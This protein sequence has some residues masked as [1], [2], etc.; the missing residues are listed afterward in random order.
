LDVAAYQQPDGHSVV[1]KM[2]DNSLTLCPWN[3][4]TWTC[5]AGSDFSYNGSAITELHEQITYNLNSNHQVSS[6]VDRNGNTIT[7]N[8]SGG[9]QATSITDTVGRTTTLSYSSGLLHQI[10]DPSGRTVTFSYYLIRCS[11][12]TPSRTGRPPRPPRW[13][14]SAS[15]IPSISPRPGGTRSATR[16]AASTGCPT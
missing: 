10:T 2:P 7:V 1:L 9:L 12:P 8:Y 16:P 6:I 11:P 15:A 3:G 13:P 5:P 14:T 4:T